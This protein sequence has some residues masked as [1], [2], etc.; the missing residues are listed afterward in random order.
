MRILF[1]TNVPSP[2]RVDF[3]NELG[4]YCDLTV[5]FERRNASNRNKDWFNEK[6]RNFKSIYLKGYNYGKDSALNPSVIKWIDKKK[7]DLFIVGGYSTP[8]GMLAIQTLRMKKIPFILNSDGGVIK[9]DKPLIKAIKRYF[10]GSASWWLSSGQETNNYLKFYGANL[11]Q[12]Y[13]YPF[14]SL[15]KEDIYLKPASIKEKQELRR[16][17]GIKNNRVVIS[18]G[19]FIPRKG[20]DLLINA[21]AHVPK[22][23][24]LLL[25]GGG[26]EKSNY[27]NQI[28]KLDLHNIEILDFIKFDDLKKYYRAA[29]LFVLPTREDI[30]GLVINEAMACGLPIISTSGCIAA[31]ELVKNN[32]C[33]QI[34]SIDNETELANAINLYL[35]DR[36]LS[37]AHSKNS[38]KEIEKYNI[39]NMAK[40]HFDIFKQILKDTK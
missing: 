29:D 37:E 11:N 22:D 10:I 19:Q 27:F 16:E 36:E 40:V 23:V 6:E 7:F 21:W 8:T 26:E 2:Y 1:L 24:Q 4:K 33:G 35:K 3:F 9:K 25:I 32:E 30:W 20:F 39:G 13:I 12:T 5:L 17:I 34:V 28:K 31:T 15:T 14:S 38:I 18:V